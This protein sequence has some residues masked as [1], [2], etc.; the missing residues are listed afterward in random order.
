M[1]HLLNWSLLLLWLVW[2]YQKFL[3]S[4]LHGKMRVPEKCAQIMSL[5]QELNEDLALV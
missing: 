1:A 5:A 3:L 4:K 2:D